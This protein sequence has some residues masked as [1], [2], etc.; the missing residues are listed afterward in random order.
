MRWTYRLVSALLVLTSII[1]ISFAL[2][3]EHVQGLEPCP[4]C[5][6]QRIG[7]IGMGLIALV[8]FIHNPISNG[9]ER[10]YALLAT[11]S[12]GWS[13]G[14]ASR[15][16]WLQ[17]L[18]PDKVPSCGPGLDY[19]VDA[20]PMK[21]VFQEVLSGSGECAAIDWTFLGQSLPVWSLL[22]FSLILLI[23][24]WQLF[25]HYSVAK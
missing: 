3:L 18:P 15:H 1:G 5:I 12:I 14:V 11:L 16:V 6:F 2:Y 20:L 4:L 10:F 24:L 9:F 22:Y 25:R 23:C 13:V 21:A 17:H 7:L 19:L 8:A